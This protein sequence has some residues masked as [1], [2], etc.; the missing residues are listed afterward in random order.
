[1]SS[2]KRKAI[3]HQFLFHL[4][5]SHPLP[6]HQCHSADQPRLYAFSLNINKY[7]HYV[8]IFFYKVIL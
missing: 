1:M 7:T 6:Q 3:L 4:L 8:K 2:I 5:C